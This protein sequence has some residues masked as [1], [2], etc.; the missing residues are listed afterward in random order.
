VGL[1][2]S[3]GYDSAGQQVSVTD[4]LGNMSTTV[5]DPDGRALATVNANGF[6]TTQVYD[7]IG[8]SLAVIDARGNRNS[9][10]QEVRRKLFRTI[11]F[12]RLR[13]RASLL[14]TR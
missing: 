14:E 10:F 4:A 7:A 5:F 1:R 8:E 12:I 9:F 11:G 6:R 3:F 2:A 13:L